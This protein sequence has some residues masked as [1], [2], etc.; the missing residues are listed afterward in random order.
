ANALAQGA[1]GLADLLAALQTKLNLASPT[2]ALAADV[3]LAQVLQALAQAS[4]NPAV[5]TALNTLAA[6]PNLPTATVHL[7]ELLQMNAATDGPSNLQLNTLDL[8][9][10]SIALF[11]AKQAITTPDPITISGSE[12]GLAGLLNAVVLRAQVVEPPVYI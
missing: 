8:L 5:T 4:S 12:L 7:G 3:T 6:T 11:N 1:V 2:E 9:T 10:G